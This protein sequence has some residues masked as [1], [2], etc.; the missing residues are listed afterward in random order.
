VTKLAK[1]FYGYFDSTA[2]DE[3]I[4]QAD[5]FAEAFRTMSGTGVGRGLAASPAGGMTVRVSPGSAMIH[6]YT[7]ALMDDGG[8]QKVFSLNASGNA[9][10]IDRIILRLDLADNAR[11]IKMTVRQ[12]TPAPDPVPPALANT[13]LI[14]EISLCGVLVTASA[15]VITA[16]DI[17]DER[18]DA[19]VCGILASETQLNWMR[20]TFADMSS[21][22]SL[23]FSTL[24]GTVT[25]AMDSFIGE[26]S[27]F[28]LLATVP[29]SGWTGGKPYTQTLTVQPIGGKELFAWDGPLCFVAANMDKRAEAAQKR[30]LAMVTDARVSGDGE[31]TMTCAARKPRVDIDIELRVLR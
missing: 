19:E 27:A 18:Q 24:K 1:E 23:N 10:R 12:G 25:A 17:T 3:R 4:Y 14:K 29:A 16:D 30:A 15:S 6:G 8:G 5:E 21:E 31:I 9:D 20:G 22:L 28:S 13:A 26:R 7:Y 2:E 11:T